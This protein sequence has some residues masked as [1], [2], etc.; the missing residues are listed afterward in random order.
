MERPGAI[1]LQLCGVFILDPFQIQHGEI[2]IPE[3]VHQSAQGRLVSELTAE[4][5]LSIILRNNG[6][7][8]K[9]VDRRTIQRFFDPDVIGET[10]AGCILIHVIT[11]FAWL[12]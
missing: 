1:D 8:S 5:S 10:Q 4:K 7:I 3:L 6:D 2:E 9:P 12:D 11:P